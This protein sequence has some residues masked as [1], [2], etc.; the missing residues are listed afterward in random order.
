[1]I[2]KKRNWMPGGCVWRPSPLAQTVGK[3]CPFPWFCWDKV[4]FQRRSSFSCTS[5]VSE[6]KS[7]A[8]VTPLALSEWMDG[9]S[10]WWLNKT[11]PLSWTKRQPRSFLD[12]SCSHFSLD[13]K[14]FAGFAICYQLFN[15]TVCED[16]SLH[17]GST[18]QAKFYRTIKSI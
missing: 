13:W 1:M 14:S 18:F 16:F 5:G 3:T 7:P 6:G 2:H 9:S 15:K 11:T 10:V 4:G 12:N 8:V 17:F